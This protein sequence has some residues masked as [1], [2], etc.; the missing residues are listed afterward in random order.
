MCKH[1]SNNFNI[2]RI[3]WVFN[4]THKNR[5][6]YLADRSGKLHVNVCVAITGAHSGIILQ[7]DLCCFLYDGKIIILD[8]NTVRSC[9]SPHQY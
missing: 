7:A 6:P 9:S 2:L 3:F 4:P 8:M 1:N 5:I